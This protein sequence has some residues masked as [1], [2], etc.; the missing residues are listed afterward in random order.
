[1]HRI[2]CVEDDPITIKLIVYLLAGEGYEVTLAPSAA[3]ARAA[4][5]RQVYDLILLDVMLPDMDNLDL[6]R[7]IQAT[8]AT[9]IILMSMRVM[10]DDVVAGLQVGAD[11]YIR[12]PF[13]PSEFL[14]RIRA[15]LRRKSG[16]V[17]HASR[18]ETADLVLDIVNNMVTLP[19]SSKTI[20]LTPT[21]ARLLLCLLSHPGRVVSRETLMMYAWGYPYQNGS[22]QVEIC[23][24][25]LR[26]KIEEEPSAPQYLLTVRGVGY[27]FQPSGWADAPPLLARVAGS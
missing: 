15:A 4:L 27:Q 11:D 21:E 10:V 25:R 3:E 7:E 6:C 22:N 12:K 2:L 8:Y 14:A 17:V 23:I 1:M 24:K 16:L 19:R 5:G 13:D 20:S 9:P 18:L 26:A